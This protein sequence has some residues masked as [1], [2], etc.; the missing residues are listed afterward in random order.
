MSQIVFSL[1]TELVWGFHDQDELPTDRINAGRPSWTSLLELFDTH[2]LPVTWAIVGHLFLDSCDGVHTDHPASSNWFA[3]DPGTSVEE[4]PSWYA[5]DLIRAIHESN[6]E[7]EIASHSFSHVEFGK[8]STDEAMARFELEEA[9][10]AAKPF[11]VDLESFVF[12]RN[13]IGHRDL[14]A[15]YGFTCYRGLQPDR[16]FD[17]RRFRTI[18]KGLTF[19]LGTSPP[20]IVTPSLDEHDLVNIPASLHLFEFEG[21][22]GRLVETVTTHPIIKQVRLGLEALRDHEDGVFHLWL[23]PNSLVTDRDRARIEEIVS[24]V[25][26]YR[27]SYGF[28]VETMNSIAE[29][30]RA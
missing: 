20:P 12:P 9:I 7:H 10:S 15:E 11:D 24:M 14:L 26:K 19:A 28:D 30:V 29:E 4:D 23:H 6:T 13:N 2:Q 17:D 25:A 27:D 8:P 22:P 3:R 18:G 21:L 1:D 5:P 16:W